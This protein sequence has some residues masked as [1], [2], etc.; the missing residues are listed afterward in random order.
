MRSRVS[1]CFHPSSNS[2]R[3]VASSAADCPCCAQAFGQPEQRAWILGVPFQF[4]AKHGLGLAGAPIQ[5]QD[6]SQR[7]A[8]RQ[9]PIRRLVVVQRILGQ[10]RLSSAAPP[11]AYSR[12]SPR[13]IGVQHQSGDLEN[14][15]GGVV[16][17]PGLGRYR[18]G[19]RR[20]TPRVRPP[21]CSSV[22]G[23]CRPCRAQIATKRAPDPGFYPAREAVR[24]RPICGNG[25]EQAS[26]WVQKDCTSGW[27]FKY[28]VR[29]P[30]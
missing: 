19:L 4:F 8:R 12:A 18:F 1:A 13:D 20:Q 23:R 21:L 6:R 10:C 24:S 27:S 28:G 2:L 25:P 17:E 7:F 3:T 14:L 11:P 26:G 30:W 9:V 22:L 5:E 15:P 29:V 16:S